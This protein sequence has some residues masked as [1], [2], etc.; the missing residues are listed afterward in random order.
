MALELLTEG[1]WGSIEKSLLDNLLRTSSGRLF[2]E[3]WVLVP[4]IGLA[5]H[6]QHQAALVNGGSSGIRFLRFPDLAVRLLGFSGAVPTPRMGEMARDHLLRNILQQ[7]VPEL[8]RDL[9]IV[10][11]GT[12]TFADAVRKTL[13]D[14][15]EAG[16][17]AGAV[18]DLAGKSAGRSRRR[19]KM[20]ADLYA[21]WLEELHE[22]EA[23]D[24]EGLVRTASEVASS[25]ED[26]FLPDLYVH[27]FY[28]LTGGQWEL[29]QSLI[30]ATNVRIFSPVYPE[31]D[32]YAAGLLKH[33]RDR[34]KQVEVFEPGE[35]AAHRP[36]SLTELWS[37]LG[38]E[39][40][41]ATESVTVV[42]APGTGREVDTALRLMTAAWLGGGRSEGTRLLTADPDLYRNHL[43]QQ[44]RSNGFLIDPLHDPGSDDKKDG[45]AGPICPARVRDLLL[46][47][48]TASTEDLSPEAMTRLLNCVICA[49]GGE[50]IPLLG[51]SLLRSVSAG[52]DLEAWGEEIGE[53]AHREEEALIRRRERIT[54]D[55]DRDG[56]KD[57]RR[58]RR[59]EAR[60]A[61]LRLSSEWT[62]IIR[63]VLMDLPESATWKEWILLL[64]DLVISV[65]SAEWSG[66]VDEGLEKLRELSVLN[67]R[68]GRIEVTQA[69]RDVE[70]SSPDGGALILHNLMEL[71]G[72]RHDLVVVLGMAEGSWPRRPSQD[73]LLLDQERKIL[74]GSDEW[75]LST[76]RRRVDEERL[77]FRLLIET[78]R[79]VVF[80]YPRLDETGRERRA[81][82]HILGLMKKLIRSDLTGSELELIA[83]RGTRRLGDTRPVAGGPL[84]GDLDRDMAAVG[85]ALDGGDRT[86]LLALWESPVFSAGWNAEYSRWKG[87]AG[88]WSGFL[89][90]ESTAGLAL[91]LLGLQ[92]EGEVSSS[93]LEGY[94]SCPWKVF[95]RQV[96][97]LPE[98]TVEEEGLLN[99]LEMGQV[100]HDVF[101]DHLRHLSEDGRW[102]PETTD[103]GDLL[104]GLEDLVA[105][106]VRGAYTTRGA[107]APLFER[108]DSRRVMGRALGW[109]RWEMGTERKESAELG[110]GASG[111]WS[112]FATEEA[113]SSGVRIGDRSIR[114]KGRWDRVDRD[115]AGHI[116]ILDYKTGRRVPE[117]DGTLSG[118]LNLQMY[119]YLLAAA[120]ELSDAG[121][122]TGGIFLH[123]KPDRPEGPPGVIDWPAKAIPAARESLDRLVDEL[124][125]SMEQG[126]FVK[127]PHEKRTDGQTGLC[128]GCPTPTICR[129]WRMEESIRHLEDD[130]LKPLN[131]LRSIDEVEE[132]GEE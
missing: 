9:E 104:V 42:S 25:L 83:A 57:E 100:L 62:G 112:V 30:E 31:T 7:R 88:P 66:E 117:K 118:G 69:I 51:T 60:A 22:I 41:G 23:L 91:R 18:S 27:G 108:I 82:P 3:R 4:H 78:G 5:R 121:S 119:L 32:A 20:V 131:M 102:P 12:M 34:A 29:L 65:A 38:D 96:L 74:A 129:A 105:E 79:H 111:G 45:A 97:G 49:R 14:L 80:L 124:L 86:A 58:M 39:G 70:R 120:A 56:L 76:S 40:Q 17:P 16:I 54:P 28:D 52:G 103:V 75:L 2:T 50:R 61:S 109:L 35:R 127:L 92:E 1:P 98:E 67:G 114:L 37:L 63:D 94:A 90:S 116:R 71:R 64:R 24:P 130:L 19:L 33:W 128:S 89:R 81:S 106:H 107:P 59:L 123:L 13:N 8:G 6:L 15:R 113:F 26:G 44:A 43:Q 68:V 87:E 73:P 126:V 110:A 84:M 53:A 48:L 21:T 122:L 115:H 11:L 101:C 72:T 77:L 46:T 10:S 85:E 36:A 55:T 125:Q 132:G 95:V 99:N 47:L 93:L